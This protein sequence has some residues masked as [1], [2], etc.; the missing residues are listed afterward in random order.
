MR[1]ATSVHLLAA[2][3]QKQHQPSPTHLASSLRE[4]SSQIYLPTYRAAVEHLRSASSLCAR[5]RAHGNL[6][7]GE[8]REGG[9]GRAADG[10]EGGVREELLGRGGRDGAHQ[11]LRG[12]A[13]AAAG[14]AQAGNGAQ[15]E[16]GSPGAHQRPRGAHDAAAVSLLPPR[17]RPRTRHIQ[18]GF[19]NHI[20]FFSNQVIDG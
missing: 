20:L 1:F 9:G 8:Q 15:A 5:D 7:G 2:A 18:V 17:H 13:A 11:R 6:H 10:R 19:S 16:G 14:A 4:Q 3:W 12:A